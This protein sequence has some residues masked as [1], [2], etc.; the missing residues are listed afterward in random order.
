MVVSTGNL[1]VKE[2]KR[3][4]EALWRA[5]LKGSVTVR[6]SERCSFKNKVLRVIEE[7]T[8]H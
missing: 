4:P 1:Q 8:S 3:F 5:S 2:R 7:N 6:F